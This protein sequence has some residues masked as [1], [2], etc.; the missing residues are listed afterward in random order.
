MISNYVILQS[1]LAHSNDRCFF[2]LF[3]L[4]LSLYSCV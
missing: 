2:V 4:S 3:F 1:V